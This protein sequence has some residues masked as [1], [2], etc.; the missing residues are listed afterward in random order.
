MEALEDLDAALTRARETIQTGHGTSTIDQWAGL[1]DMYQRSEYTYNETLR[2]MT[3]GSTTPPPSTSDPRNGGGRNG[4]R[5]P[6]GGKTPPGNG[7]GFDLSSVTGH[8][9]FLPAILGVGAVGAYLLLT[10]DKGK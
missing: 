3:E 1:Q 10:G 2:L 5:V 6:P 4:G 7:G 9:A 8:P